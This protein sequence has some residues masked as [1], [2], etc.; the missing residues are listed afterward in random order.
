LKGVTEP[1][2]IEQP[3]QSAEGVVAGQTVLQLEKAAQEPFLGLRK[4]L[5]GNR[6]LT[7]AQ[8]RAERNDQ[9][10]VEVVQPG[11][12]GA[13][14]LQT[15]P[16]ATHEAPHVLFSCWMWSNQAQ[17]TSLVAAMTAKAG[18]VGE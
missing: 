7:A 3:E 6:T 1:D 4:S 18:P 13:R 16:G 5:H 15:L 2:R 10:F 14:V 12:A 11:I 9:E 8:H 17:R